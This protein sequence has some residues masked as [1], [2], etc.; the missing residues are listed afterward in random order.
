MHLTGKNIQKAKKKKKTL[1]CCKGHGLFPHFNDARKK[2]F[3]LREEQ[4]MGQSIQEWTK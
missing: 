2:I 3:W 1:L 4:Y